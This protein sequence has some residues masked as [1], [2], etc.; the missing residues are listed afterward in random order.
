MDL[1]AGTLHHVGGDGKAGFAVA[2]G[3][4]KEARFNG[5]KGIAVGPDGMVYVVDSGNH[6]LRK[7]DPAKGTMTVVAG[8]PGRG[9]SGATAARR[10]RRTEQPARR[11]HRARRHDL[12][13]R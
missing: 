12:H 6:V 9:G 10:P 11:L 1:K 5:P 13:R 2:D 3:P 7:I 8:V 4:V